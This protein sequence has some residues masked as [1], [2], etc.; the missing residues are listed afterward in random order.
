[1][2]LVLDGSGSSA[3][4]SIVRWNWTL[5][6][7]SLPVPNASSTNLLT[8][9]ANTTYSGKN[10]RITTLNNTPEYWGTL[11][12]IDDI[13][14]SETSDQFSIPPDT[15]F[16]PPMSLHLAII[17]PA[18][19]VSNTTGCPYYNST[20]PNPPLDYPIITGSPVTV[21]SIT[22]FNS[23]LSATLSDI[24]NNPVTNIP[25]I[26]VIDNDPNPP[27]NCFS[28]FPMASYTDA[29]GVAY[30]NMQQSNITP[31]LCSQPITMH[32]QVGKLTSPTILIPGIT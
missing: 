10:V 13:G 9:W 1:M 22:Q 26:F 31:P 8:N 12:V 28:I 20:T 29:N 32:A 2:F 14:M 17:A 11:T 5:Y 15:Q 23:N 3:D 24:N 25:V 4:N 30:T 19:C 16:S 7:R 18:F 27:H 6:D 21:S